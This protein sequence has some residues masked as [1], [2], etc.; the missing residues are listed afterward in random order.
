MAS[1]TVA[2]HL[3]Y[4][5][6]PLASF[7]AARPEFESF[8]VGAY[9]FSHDGASP[10][11]I[12][13]LQRSLT[14]SM[15]GFWEGPGGAYEPGVDE[16]LL[17]GVV[18]EVLEETGLHVSRIVE[19]VAVDGWTHQRRNG[20]H[21]CIA[22]Y[23]FIVEVHE[24]TRSSPQGEPQSVT[25]GDIPVRLEAS[26]HQAFEWA[27]EADVR[28]SVQSDQGRYQFPLPFVG[29]QAPN[30]LR[31]FELWTEHQNRTPQHGVIHV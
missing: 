22:K 13:L 12:L 15:G 11:R 26:E 6:T 14:D 2:P 5:N 18:R 10:L 30:I 29:H 31:A 8:G 25:W 24:V 20:A 4:F 16:T 19:L 1:Y 9:I 23:S 3:E 7:T 21:I 17:D 28:H 27:T